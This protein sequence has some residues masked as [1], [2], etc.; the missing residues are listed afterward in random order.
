MCPVGRRARQQ[1]VCS[2]TVEYKP[3]AKRSLSTANEIVTRD[4]TPERIQW[5]HA[6]ARAHVCV[7]VCVCV[8]GV[9][10]IFEALLIKIQFPG[11]QKLVEQ[12]KFLICRFVQTAR[13]Q[14]L[15]ANCN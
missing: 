2:L 3:K 10:S 8:R 1:E 4:L 5:T 9:T 7:C 14:L 15:T 12:R 6:R 11:I 13:L